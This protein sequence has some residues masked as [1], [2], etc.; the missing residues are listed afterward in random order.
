M[1]SILATAVAAIV[2]FV[3]FYSV[4]RR[5]AAAYRGLMYQPTDVAVRGLSRQ[6]QPLILMK[7]VGAP[8]LLLEVIFLVLSLFFPVFDLAVLGL[9]V[10]IIVF[11]VSILL[12][13]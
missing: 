1:L 3:S 7:R 9:S 11:S 6:V 2:F 8:L 5:L 10:V 4:T 13:R 12:R